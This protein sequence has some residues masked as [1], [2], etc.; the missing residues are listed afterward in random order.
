MHCRK[1]FRSYL[2]NIRV[3]KESQENINA[4]LTWYKEGSFALEITPEQLEKSENSI[5]SS[6]ESGRIVL[7][8]SA[9][10]DFV[11]RKGEEK[12]NALYEKYSNIDK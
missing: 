2:R 8:K 1:R 10:P 9:F 6:L 3:N 11:N 4:A 12:L 5:K 7:P